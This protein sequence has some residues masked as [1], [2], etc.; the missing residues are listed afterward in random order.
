LRVQS[1]TDANLV[2]QI[3]Q[4]LDA[5]ESEAIALAIE[6]RADFILMDELLG[7]SEAVRHGLTV[8]GTIGILLRAKRAGLLGS[9]APL[10]HELRHE[11]GFFLSDQL[12]RETLKLAGE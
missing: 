11:L 6:L 10:L 9:L 7:R 4:T 1:P 2:G 5:G 8:T 12:V 3:G